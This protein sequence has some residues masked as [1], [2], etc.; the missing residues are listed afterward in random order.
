MTHASF[1]YLMHAI[2]HTH[3]SKH[4]ISLKHVQNNMHHFCLWHLM[5]GTLE[6]RK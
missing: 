2:A 6:P 5:P 3:V 4:A 1:L